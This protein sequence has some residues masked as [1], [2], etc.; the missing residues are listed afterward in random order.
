MASRSLLKR[1][2]PVLAVLIGLGAGASAF[3]YR[4]VPTMW[5]EGALPSVIARKERFVREVTAEGNLRAVTATPIVAPQRSRMPLKLAWMVPDSS[6]VKEGEVIIRFD[7]T[8]MLEQL[9]AGKS[10]LDS[11]DSKIKNERLQVDTTMRNRDRSA[12][13]AKQELEQTQRFQSRNELIFSRNQII[14]SEIDQGLFTAKM[15]HAGAAKSIE[16]D[17]SKGKLDMLAVERRAAEIQIKQAEEALKS[18]EVV[19]PHAGIIVLRRDWRGNLPRA[20]D[21]VWPG[22]QIAD[23]PLIDQ[24]EAEVFVLEADAGGLA[25]GKQATVIIEAHPDTVYQGTVKQV[26]KLAK[27]RFSEVPVQY[28][29]VTVSLER[30]DS[31]LM[32]P[33]QRVRATIMA[34]DSEAIVLPRQAIFTKDG[35]SIVYR[36]NGSRYEPVEVTL[37]PG[38]P[39]RVVI[40]AGVAEG[41]RIALSDPTGASSGEPKQQE[42]NAGGEVAGTGPAAGAP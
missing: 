40:E 2:L 8:E 33:G 34:F 16:R 36:M 3:G 20:G 39:G 6:V 10:S 13:I 21:S 22:Q 18:M 4:F 35:K 1:R 24:M 11:A 29:G 32:K 25:E 17:V 15:G 7:N 5:Q 31:A 26:D 41:D 14:E 28:F 42:Q 12:E 38:T 19:A 30:T 23:I 37:G 9:E 27:P